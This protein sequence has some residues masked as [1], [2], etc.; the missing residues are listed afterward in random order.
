LGRLFEIRI[1]L[2]QAAHLFLELVI[3]FFQV[4]ED[5]VLLKNGADRADDPMEGT[6]PRREGPQAYLMELIS[7][8]AA[9]DLKNDENKGAENQ[10]NDNECATASPEVHHLN[11]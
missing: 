7:S 9:A 10:G 1:L 11:N 5:N 2:L 3:L 6:L 8:I 4:Y